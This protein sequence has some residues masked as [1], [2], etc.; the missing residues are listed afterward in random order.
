M[1]RGPATH[2]C[3]TSEY[4]ADVYYLGLE[5]SLIFSIY[6]MYLMNRKNAAKEVEEC[7]S[8]LFV[9]YKTTTL[10]VEEIK[11]LYRIISL[12]HQIHIKATFKMEEIEKLPCTCVL[13]SAGRELS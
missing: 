4:F 7:L 6:V 1:L 2:S 3:I 10:L 9:K 11:L 5:R 8:P 13:V 12:N